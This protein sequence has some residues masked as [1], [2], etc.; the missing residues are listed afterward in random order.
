MELSDEEIAGMREY[1]LRGGVL[2]VGDPRGNSQMQTFLYYV[3][4][5]LPGFE[6]KPLDVSTPYLMPFSPIN[7]RRFARLDRYKPIS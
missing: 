3:N 1:L 6:I 5:A 4:K 2:L 7:R